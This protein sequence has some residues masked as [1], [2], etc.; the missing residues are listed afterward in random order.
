MNKYSAALRGL[1]VFIYEYVIIFWPHFIAFL[2]LSSNPVAYLY[3][4]DINT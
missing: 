4:T 2:C 1:K 3:T